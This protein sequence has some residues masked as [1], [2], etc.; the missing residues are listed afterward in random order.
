VDILDGPRQCRQRRQQRH[1]PV[2]L[3]ELD[4]QLHATET[5]SPRHQHQ[6]VVSRHLRRITRLTA[7]ARLPARIAGRSLDPREVEH[8][9]RV[10]HRAVRGERRQ[11]RRVVIAPAPDHQPRPRDRLSLGI[12]HVPT[13][14]S[15]GRAVTTCSPRFG[16]NTHGSRGSRCVWRN[17]AHTTPRQPGPANCP[18]SPTSTPRRRSESSATPPFAGN[19]GS[20]APRSPA[21][22]RGRRCALSDLPTPLRS[23]SSRL[24]TPKAPPDGPPATADRRLRLPFPAFPPDPSLHHNHSSSAATSGTTPAIHPRILI[25]ATA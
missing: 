1:L 10:A 22:H 25:Q 19:A 7:P 21:S 18:S 2:F 12:H 6:C 9:L 8:P 20:P 5:R 3:T 17:S 24:P 11:R 16:S 23:E 14:R 4:R 13:I 15:S